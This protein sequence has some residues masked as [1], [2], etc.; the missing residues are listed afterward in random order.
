M[1][2]EPVIDAGADGFLATLPVVLWLRPSARPL[3]PLLTVM[4]NEADVLSNMR[5][6]E[7]GGS[8][9]VRQEQGRA[10][11]VCQAECQG[12]QP[13]EAPWAHLQRIT[14]QLIIAD[15]GNPTR[16]FAHRAETA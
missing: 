9:R 7:A 10:W 6:L 3:H 2:S 8:L 1:R 13:S 16:C 15:G 4:A 14:T 11:V 12:P 5:A